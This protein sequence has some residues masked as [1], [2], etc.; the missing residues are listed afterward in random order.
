VVEVRGG[1]SPGPTSPFNI[2]VASFLLRNFDQ[3]EI[4]ALY[5]QHT[6]DTGQA[7]SPEAVARARYWTRGQP[8]LVNALAARCVD[9]TVRDRAVAVQA[10]HVDEAAE[11]LV[12][13]RV[14]HLDNL[15][16]RM[17]EP[18]VARIVQAAL[19]GDENETLARTSDDF[20]YVRDLGL[21]SEGPAGLE[22]ANP[23][24]AEVLTRQLTVDVQSTVP[25]PG[26]PWR[27]PDGTLDFP[28]LVDAWRA[29]WRA[30]AEVLELGWA[31]GYPEGVPHFVFLAFL[32]RVVNGGG[33]VDREFASGR[34]RIDLVVRFGGRRHVVELKRVPPA[35]L[36]FDRVVEEGVAQ[37]RARLDQLGEPEG[38]MIVFDQRPGRTWEERMWTRE[39]EADG[40][41]LHLVGG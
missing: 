24:Y 30:N 41:T 6:A 27:R 14:T 2:L 19:L 15:G 20:V 5:A 1:T 31:A 37:L 39:V 36:S 17:R 7:F 28:A 32:Q 23:M 3:A 13:T 8:L 11:H 4:A 34:G 16:E 12:R 33:V 29:W 40:R 25:D 21:L 26:W 9:A 35:K 22:P 38:W 10:A 18:R